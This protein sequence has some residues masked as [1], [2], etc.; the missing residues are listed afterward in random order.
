VPQILTCSR[1]F[2]HRPDGRPDLAAPARCRHTSSRAWLPLPAV[3]DEQ[4]PQRG[5][6]SRWPP[7][8]SA[9]SLLWRAAPLR[10]A[11]MVTVAGDGHAWPGTRHPLSC[12]QRRCTDGH[13]RLDQ[14]VLSATV[15]VTVPRPCSVG[16]HS[17]PPVL[18]PVLDGL[19][20]R[21]EASM[22]AHPGACG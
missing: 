19:L 2:L 20:L 13:A 6:G 22:D 7:L 21:R 14:P 18:C 4:A 10:R 15:R 5:F 1:S 9:S 3:S 8:A 11:R 17:T 12:R 16:S